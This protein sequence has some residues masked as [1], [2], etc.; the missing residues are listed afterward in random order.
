MEDVKLRE[1]LHNYVEKGDEKLLKLM[2]VLAKEYN[3]EDDS[4]HQFTT[5]EIKL[6]EQRRTSRISGKSK[7]YSREEAHNM[8]IG[9]KGMK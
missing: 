7:V 8:I 4:D 9:K 6:F 3:D 1:K 2:Y 5:D